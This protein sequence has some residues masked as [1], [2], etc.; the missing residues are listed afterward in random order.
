MTWRSLA[1]SRQPCRCSE[2]QPLSS[3]WPRTPRPRCNIGTNNCLVTQ[4]A[5]VAHF[6][7]PKDPIT[8]FNRQ[9]STQS[10]FYPAAD[11][12][13]R[14]LLNYVQF[15]FSTSI[16]DFV[17]LL[18]MHPSIRL[19]GVTFPKVRIF[20]VIA[21]K[22]PVFAIL[23]SLFFPKN[24]AKPLLLCCR[25]HGGENCYRKWCDVYIRRSVCFCIKAVC[26]QNL[27]NG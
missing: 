18:D 14:Q 8:N 7:I 17:C 3:W 24:L 23:V 19:H 1:E 4:I 9:F 12:N 20:F 6:T 10:R 16:F 5:D 11:L 15:F 22:S 2:A 27:E 25:W 21:V 26:Q 13:Y